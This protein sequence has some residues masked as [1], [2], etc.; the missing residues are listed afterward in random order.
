MSRNHLAILFFMMSTLTLT[1][2]ARAAALPGPAN[3]CRFIGFR[4]F[5]GFTVAPSSNAN[6]TV[7]LSKV[8]EAPKVAGRGPAPH[9]AML[10]SQKNRMPMAWNELIVSWNA[11]AP[12]ETWLKV[13]A[14]AIYPD[15]ETK[16]YTMGI[17]SKDSKEHPRVSVSRQRD[18]DG[19]VNQ[20]TLVLKRP[21][22]DVQLRVTL[23]GPGETL[24]PRLK[25]LGISLLDS[26]AEPAPL[27]P[28]RAAW[29]KIIPTTERSQKSY[30]QEE[31][32]CSP[33]STSMVLTRWGELLHRPELTS[34]VPEVAAGVYDDGYGGTGNWPFNTAYAGSFP[35]MRAYVTR[36]SDISELEDWIVSGIPVVIS[37]RWDMMLPGRPFDDAGHL[38]VCIGFTKNGDL[39]INDPATNFKKGQKVRHIFT[40]Q[41]I[42]KAWQSSRNTVY[43]IYPETAKIPADRFGHWDKP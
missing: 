35:G 23:G 20:D 13:E 16:F 14:R 29:G 22:G 24:R 25:F 27:R 41:N 7:L 26:H 36:F 9:G 33:T 6:E 42:I 39:V 37:A 10:L 40:R 21:A 31:G 8:I 3:Q 19:T 32:W 43:L 11:D 5:S 12:P 34:D 28:N 4:K 38:S 30:P 17:W 15:H 2:S 18:S 1:H